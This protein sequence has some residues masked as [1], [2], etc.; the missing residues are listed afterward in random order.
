MRLGFKDN[1]SNEEVP[2]QLLD[3]R[4]KKF[5]NKEVVSVKVL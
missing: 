2:I 1:L 3:R 5:R 4:V